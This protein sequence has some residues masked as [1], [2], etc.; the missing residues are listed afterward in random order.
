MSFLTGGKQL[1]SVVERHLLDHVNELLGGREVHVDGLDV[2][3]GE[4]LLVQCA[5]TLAG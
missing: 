5:L 1:P 4:L 2:G 3:T